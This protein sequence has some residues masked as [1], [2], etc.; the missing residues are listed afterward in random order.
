[1]EGTKS[2]TAANAEKAFK[3]SNFVQQHFESNIFRLNCV[4]LT[5]GCFEAFSVFSHKKF[6]NKKSKTF[7][8]HIFQYT[9]N[10]N[11]SIEL[12]Q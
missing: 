11:S 8:I 5:A 4:H 2:S 10:T 6:S 9:S 12:L 1:M 3:S 7:P